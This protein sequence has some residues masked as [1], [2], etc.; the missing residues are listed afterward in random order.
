MG[1]K[2]TLGWSVYFYLCYNISILEVLLHTNSILNKLWSI[3]AL[4]IKRENHEDLHN[5]RVDHSIAYNELHK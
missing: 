1:I 2:W 3:S 5:T 4:Y